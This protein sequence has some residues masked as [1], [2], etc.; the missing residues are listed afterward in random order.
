MAGKSRL[1]VEGWANARVLWEADPTLT[2]S[3]IADMVSVSKQAVQQ[4]AKK[5]GWKKLSSQSDL[6]RRA[7]EKADQSAVESNAVIARAAAVVEGDEPLPSVSSVIEGKAVDLKA[8]VLDRHRREVDGIRTHLYRAMQ[9]SDHEKAKLAKTSAEA[10]KIVQEL[11]RKSWGFEKDGGT[12]V[13]G[14]IT[15][16]IERK[17]I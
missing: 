2:H 4:R 16:I 13:P 9:N 15:V 1:S 14:T 10:M 7:Y 17:E 11:E 3:G 12:D 6:A 5:E 8:K